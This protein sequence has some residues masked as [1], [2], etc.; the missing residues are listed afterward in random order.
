MPSK[1]PLVCQSTL[2][3]SSLTSPGLAGVECEEVVLVSLAASVVE[4]LADALFLVES[5]ALQE[6]AAGTLDLGQFADR[7]LKEARKG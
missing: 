4:L 3:T 1:L 7:G 6:I 5:V 2:K